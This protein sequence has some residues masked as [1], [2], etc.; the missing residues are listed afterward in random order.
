MKKHNFTEDDKQKVIDFLNTVAKHAKFTMDTEELV[1][2]F[3]A[4]AHMQQVILPKINDNIL[5]IKKVVEPESPPE[6]EKKTKPP[7]APKSI[8]KAKSGKK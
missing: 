7:K 1:A 4:L 3:K 5:E 2:Y 8:K 6:P